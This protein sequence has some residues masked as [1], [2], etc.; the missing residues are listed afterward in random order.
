MERAPEL[1]CEGFVFPETPRW[2]RGSFYCCSIDEGLIYRIDSDGSRTLLVGIDDLVSGFCFVSRDSEEMV[3]SSITRKK[4]LRW[5][6]RSLDELADVASTGCNMINDMVRT[7]RGDCY[8]GSLSFPEGVQPR[9]TVQ[10]Q[11]DLLEELSRRHGVSRETLGKLCEVLY[12]V[13]VT[14]DGRTLIVASTGWSNLLAYDLR[15]DG[16]LSNRRVFATIPGSA[17]DG[18][19]LDAEG[20]VW[21][22]TH[23]HVY[24]VLEGG[25]ITDHVD[26]GAYKASACM[27]GGDDLRTLLITA[28]LSHDRAVIAGKPSGRLYTLRVDVPGA[29]LPSLYQHTP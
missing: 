3:I 17:P 4:L 26:M 13:V 23:E 29:G 1:L 10:V 7:E 5:D 22:T 8:V 25:E 24:R 6:G 15:A 19:C 28:P 20:G 9:L 12:E 21:V 14:P 18:I 2:H 27:L 16:T 11:E